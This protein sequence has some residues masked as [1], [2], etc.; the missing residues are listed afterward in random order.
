MTMRVVVLISGRGSN[1]QA[2]IE[3]RQSGAYSIVGVASNNP[4]A[5]GLQAASQA[6]IASCAVAHRDF[7]V[8]EDFERALIE[9]IDRW[10]PDLIVLAGFMRVLTDTFVG[11]YA[12]RMINIHPSL[13]PEFP[14]L[15][16]HER[17]LRA[18]VQWHGAS[19]HY[20]TDELDGG[21][22]IS[23]TR[24]RVRADDDAQS[25]AAR[26]LPKEHLLLPA[27]VSEIASG[28]LGF[29]NGKVIFN[30]NILQKA[31]EFD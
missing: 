7:A 3:A 16:T 31:L 20:V 4:T 18:A 22:V 27:T 23:R 29:K 12:G 21:P 2:L 5:A 28:R 10:Q 24:V 6:G 26:I 15:N 25:L 9:K 30:G 14:G 1:L 13:L 8:R 19:V 17:A 11:H